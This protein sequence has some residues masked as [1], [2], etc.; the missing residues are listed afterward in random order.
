MREADQGKRAAAIR[1]RLSWRFVH[2]NRLPL[3]EYEGDQNMK[4]RKYVWGLDLSGRDQSPERER[5]VTIDGAG[6]IG[7]LI[8]MRDVTGGTNYFC[9]Y[10]A[11]GNLGQL[12]D[13]SDGSLDAK[14][15]YDAYGNTIA[16]TGDY[17]ADNP[18][19]FST[20][21]FDGELDYA[22]TTNDGL[23][24]FGYRYY[25]PRLGRWVSRDPIA[26]RGSLNLYAYVRNRPTAITDPM[27][28]QETTSQPTSQS[29]CYCGPDI[30]QAII[31]HLNAF[32]A[33]RR[34]DLPAWPET[35]AEILSDFARR[36]GTRFWQAVEDYDGPCGAGPCKGTATLCDLCMSGQHI[37]HILWMAYLS[38][39]YGQWLARTAGREYERRNPNPGDI[40]RADLAFN[41]LALC[42]ARAMHPPGSYTYFNGRAVITVTYPADYLTKAELCACVDELSPAER[43]LFA[44]KRGRGSRVTGYDSCRPCGDSIS[45]PSE[46]ELPPL[47]PY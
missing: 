20:K 40:S 2:H 3:V 38:E 27:G 18:I 5:G 26:E 6:G 10:D 17:A 28:L 41:D 24:Y 29:C 25:S 16:S 31:D 13:R 14:Y 8:S 33:R 34:G 36:N 19:R 23:Y 1:A 32:V 4:V 35:G 37:D 11:N 15:E 7:G 21:Y 30:T 12:V 39:S 44:E 45:N 43:E 47:D 22:Q 42:F 9:F 46:L